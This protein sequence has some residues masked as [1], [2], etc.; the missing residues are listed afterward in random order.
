MRR[1]LCFTVPMTN[2]AHGQML[3]VPRMLWFS[4]LVACGFFFFIQFMKNGL[5]TDLNS[6]D[7]VRPDVLLFV[8]MGLVNAVASWILPKLIAKAACKKLPPVRNEA[9]VLKRAFAPLIIRLALAEAVTLMG[10]VAAEMQSKTIIM[11]PFMLI[12][13]MIFLLS[14][15]TYAFLRDLQR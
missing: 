7:I 13:L 14:F 6:S 15:P 2:Q 3:L 11:L 8:V 9:E 10:F 1:E 5:S 12:T 4:M